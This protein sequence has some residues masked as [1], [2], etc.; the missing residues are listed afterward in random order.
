[1]QN[2]GLAVPAGEGGHESAGDD[3]GRVSRRSV[4]AAGVAPVLLG[5]AGRKAGAERYAVTY[6]PFDDIAPD[7]LTLTQSWN[8]LGMDDR[9]R[10]YIIWTST[11]AD[12][13]EDSALFRYTHA[14]GKREFLGTFIDVAAKQNNLGATEQ[15]PKGHTRIIQ[16]G[17][18]MYMASQ[19][20]HDFK[21][22]IDDLPTYRG[23]HLFA[24]N[25]DTGAFDDVSR[26]LPGGVLIDHQ[27]VVALNYSPEHHL[28]VGLSHPHSDIVL[29]DLARGEVRKVVPGI[30]WALN[31]M[32]SREVVVTRTG[33][34]YTY[35][36]PEDPTLRDMTNQVWVYD[37]KTGTMKKTGQSL[38]GGFW[39]GQA[40]DRTRNKIYLSTVSG[41]LYALNVARG[42]F[43]HLGHFVDA[44]AYRSAAQYRAMYLYGISLTADERTLLGVPIIAPTA[45]AGSAATRL[46]S[47]DLARRTFTKQADMTREAFTGSNH[48][49]RKG[50]I[51][52]AAFD[53]DKNC[54]L[55][56]LT[57][58]G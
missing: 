5:G 31:R 52:Q 25:V 6:V 11:R 57:P 40:V 12:G 23:A 46:T 39:N 51:Y 32:V 24:F 2:V 34:I 27:G 43:S 15:I 58:R 1:M 47:Y 20:F 29:Y 38:R 30:P 8:A 13:R 21:A 49:D 26:T 33:E 10:V 48:R 41:E 18:T 55:A 53:W 50:N 35:R 17:R 42:T 14:T 37:L 4:L 56:V 9:D 16:V 19:G 22:G 36:G 7:Y 3:A 54:R 44:D 45:G 28:L